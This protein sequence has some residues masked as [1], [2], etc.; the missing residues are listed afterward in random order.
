MNDN[1]D[2][3][4]IG[5]DSAL[6]CNDA[7]REETYRR[8]GECTERFESLAD[9]IHTLAGLIVDQGGGPWEL[10]TAAID[11]ARHVRALVRQISEKADE[12]MAEAAVLEALAELT[13]G[14]TI[15]G[16]DNWRRSASKNGGAL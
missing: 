1:D 8:A 7:L 12:L 15:G 4:T 5:N 16:G 2:T 11:S 14:E 13:K 10:F 9:Q 6:R 3:T